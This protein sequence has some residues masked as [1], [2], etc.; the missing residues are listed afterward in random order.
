[1]SKCIEKDGKRY[2]L[3]RGKW[4]EIPAE[5]VGK[6]PTD[7]TIRDRPSKLIGKLKRQVKPGKKNLKRVDR[8]LQ[9]TVEE[10]L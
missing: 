3:R 4:V 8:Y 1:M 5:W 6:F 2:R 7:K 10:H 9:E